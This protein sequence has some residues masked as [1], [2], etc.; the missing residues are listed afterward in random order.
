VFNGKPLY[1]PKQLSD[2]G[3]KH[4]DTVNIEPM[5]ICVEEP[6]GKMHT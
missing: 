5:Q 3:I 1:D 6:N 4:E 2:H